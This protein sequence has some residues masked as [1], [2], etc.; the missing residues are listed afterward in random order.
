MCLDAVRPVFIGVGG[1]C[2]DAKDLFFGSIILKSYKCVMCG[3]KF[4][5][6]SSKNNMDNQHSDSKHGSHK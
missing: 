4:G 1:V 3:V 2:V 6:S 5:W